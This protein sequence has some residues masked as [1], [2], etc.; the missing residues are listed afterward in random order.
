MALPISLSSL[1]FLFF[2]LSSA[3]DMSIISYNID[4][5]PKSWRSDYQVM[6]MQLL[7][8]REMRF[9]I[10]KYNLRFI[11]EHNSKNHSYEVG[12]TRFADITNEEYRAMFLGT[13]SDPKRRLM[14]SRNP[15]RRYAFR[16]GDELPE[17]VD[18]RKQGA[19]NPI[20]DQGSCGSCWA[21]STIATAEGINKIVTG[22]LISP[23][24][25]ELLD[26]DRVIDAGCSGGLM[27]NAFQAHVIQGPYIQVT[28]LFL[29][30]HL[31]DKAVSIDGF[32]DVTPFDE[33]A[34]QKAVANQ[35]V[36]VAIE[37]SGMGLQFYKSNGYF[38]IQRNVFNTNTG[39]CGIAMESSYPIKNTQKPGG[40]SEASEK[41]N[42]A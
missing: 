27:D 16:A 5:H 23:S 13:K 3:K 41:I 36:S 32:E 29:L 38:R 26:C 25:Q 18:W 12:L 40:S 1:F 6:N 15:S 21:F 9:E 31:N 33:K 7:G 24:E 4:H 17:S 19:V 42:R 30:N 11:D 2:T 14:K 10:F 35:P 28:F 34:L 39:K 8:E 20:K 22:E 37:A